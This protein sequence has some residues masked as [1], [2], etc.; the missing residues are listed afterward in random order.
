M[1]TKGKEIPAII[2]LLNKIS[3][4]KQI[5]TIDAIG[6]QTKIA[7]KII[8]EKGD[9]VLAVKGNQ[10]NLHDDIKTYLDDNGFK[11]TIKNLGNYKETKEKAHGQLEIRRYYQ[12]N[13]IKWLN[14]L[15][16]WQGLSSIGMVE[17]TTIKEGKQNTVTRYYISSLKSDINLF[18][19]CVRGHWAVES[20]HWHLDVTFREDANQ[21]L[22]KVAAENLNIIR[23]WSLA[24]F[25]LLV[26]DKKYSLKKKRFALSCGFSKF[27]EQLMAL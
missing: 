13:D 23:K 19:E 5:V 18:A 8:A 12:T 9:Y 14:N 7:E 26:L 17:T 3:V 6:T 20:M 27:I 22:N 16:H 25:K 24:I 4:K 2:E 10:G 15:E 21:T 1:N 11:E